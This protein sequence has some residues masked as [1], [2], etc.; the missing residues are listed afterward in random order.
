MRYRILG[1]LGVQPVVEHPALQRRKP[2]IVL[3]M[4]L[5]HA[6]EVVSTDALID[7]V[8]GDSPPARARGSL[9][10]YV[11]HLRKAL[12]EER[13]VS[14][15]SGYMLRV[16]PGELDAEVFERLVREASDAP[17]KL[18]AERLR[19]ALALWRGPALA[20]L[21]YE[22]FTQAAIKALD[23]AR[24]TAF[25]DL[26]AAD[27]EL[28]R[29]AEAAVELEALVA[30]YPWRERLR[31]QLMLA[32]YR[33]G[34]QAEALEVYRDG[35]R[36]LREELGLDPGNE[37]RELERAILTQDEA[38]GAPPVASAEREP[39]PTVRKVVTVLFADVAG[40]TRLASSVDPELLRAVMGRFFGA[41]RAVAER[42]G[43]TLEKFSGDEVMVVF[44][45]PTLHEDDA[46]RAVRAAAEMRDTLAELNRDLERDHGVRLEIRIGVNT[47]EVV[48]GDLGEMPLVTGEA[49]NVGKRLQE[50]AAPGEVL[51][52]PVTVSLTRGLVE[53]EQFGTLELRGRPEPLATHRLIGLADDPSVTREE[54]G[55]LVGRRRELRR[56]RAAYSRVRGK[57]R[58]TLALVVGEAG[59]GKTR[60]VR[61]LVN[62]IDDARI[63]VA[64]CVSYGEG[65]T[66]LPLVD[67]V[68][69]ATRETSLDEL[70]EDV[71]EAD[72]VA[73]VLRVLAGELDEPF[74]V[75]EVS[76]AVQR[77]V[78]TLAKDKPVLLIV[79]DVHW[80]EP[81]FLDL[82]EQLVE[83]THGVPLLVLA[84]ARPEL[85]DRR[86]H[87]AD[88]ADGPAGVRLERLSD[89]DTKNLVESH[90]GAH[91]E[92][93]VLDRVV[94]TAEG[95]PLFAE[96]L[97]SLVRERG[98]DALG[99]LPPTV[100][101][102]IASR[103]DGLGRR[104]R[105]AIERAAV[106]GRD[107]RAGELVALSPPDEAAI[108]T[109]TLAILA[110]AGFVRRRRVAATDDTFAFQHVLI[111][112]AAYAA[113][114][115]AR[116]AEL[117][118][119]LGDWLAEHGDAPDEIVGFHLESAYR[120]LAALGPVGRHGRQLA[121][122]A[123]E[124]LGR[125]GMRAFKRSDLSA[126]YGL[127][128]RAVALQPEHDRSRELLV[129]LG[130]AKLL[131]GD[132][133]AAELALREALERAESA[134]DLRMKARAEMEL[135]ALEL[136]GHGE[137]DQLLETATQAA[138]LFGMLRDHRSLGRAW[139]H[140]GWVQGGYF[141]QNAEWE[142]ASERALAEYR[143]SGWPTTRCVGELASALYYGPRRVDDARA[144]MSA[145]LDET[146][147]RGGEANV[148]SA[149]ALLE[150]MG[151]NFDLA[152]DLIARA[153]AVYD[154]LGSTLASLIVATQAGAIELLA[155]EPES[156]VR[157]YRESCNELERLGFH[158]HLSTEAALLADALCDLGADDEAEKWAEI[159]RSR[160]GKGDLSAAFSW[161]SALAKI[162][163]RQ[164]S[165]DEAERLAREAVRLV[166]STDALNQQGNVLL[167]LG[168]ILQQAGRI[169]EA[170]ATVDAAVEAFERK[171]NVVTAA[172]A[173]EIRAV[174]APA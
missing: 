136:H 92:Q 125:A 46:L 117:H 150:G 126:T 8:W 94:S 43:G 37:L 34:R 121:G 52:A 113:I 73:R 167:A 106:V 35:R 32:L 119:R 116:R 155:G 75:G 111:R 124:C 42:H 127:L 60:L 88:H 108:V 96:Q 123:S 145:L 152:R 9:Q 39:A 132:S 82:V 147:G 120:N 78:A 105:S 168:E 158:A 50:A 114:P 81:A 63:L 131:G 80:G 87:W 59:I 174:L 16:E 3:A 54:P 171:G 129:E 79:D 65:A 122:E 157:L 19:S 7:A 15:G 51:L 170:S 140:V 118:E 159:A 109:Q 61:E 18:R 146:V 85:I 48:A 115:K 160:A 36:L 23:D 162:R 17:A 142:K 143:A 64:R 69:Q 45:V 99:S 128:E 90:G 31:G 169:D 84:L 93:P 72:R 104:E 12:G 166:Q 1:P 76:W 101:A 53:S 137:P 102:L 49:V 22:G 107:F 165:L 135:R 164:G 5:L 163:A 66:Y 148:Y 156:A 153:R 47:G 41:M 58:V 89:D 86:P 10:N 77:F 62:G 71:A 149:L 83:H 95:N 100:E 154:E 13:L 56:L 27:L 30:E 11:S 57:Q 20:D 2:R 97:F 29:H 151:G 130:L 21:A 91:L 161:R 33:S 44:G 26:A 134:D 112:D 103:L 138:E 172:R 6:N 68:R 141:C 110:H 38:L 55:R 25:E 40:S 28:G 74:A 70:L 4:L 173:R 24:G 98:P 14:E 67:V 144:R 139:V 133:E